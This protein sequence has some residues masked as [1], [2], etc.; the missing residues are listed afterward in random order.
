MARQS[1]IEYP[2]AF[3]HVIVRGNQQQDIFL[4]EDDRAQYLKRLAL[5]KKKHRFYLYAYTLMTNHIHLLLETGDVP[6]SK[7]MQVLNFTYTQYFNRKYNKKGHLFQGRYKSFLCDRDSYLLALVRY[8]HLNP[9]RAGMVK[10]PE[11]YEWSSHRQYLMGTEG[12]I[13]SQEVLMQFSQ[14]RSMSIELYEKFVAEGL[15]QGKED[16]FYEAVDQQILGDDDFVENVTKKVNLQDSPLKKL[17]FKDITRT[18]S[19][20]TGVSLEEMISSKRADETRVSRSLLL[21]VC[22]ERGYTLKELVGPLKRDLSV[23]SRWGKW[24]KEDVMIDLVEKAQT[25][26]DANLQA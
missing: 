17:P 21:R 16:S 1:R 10:K 3:Y 22:C 26:L 19:T 2:G 7:I 14:K 6:I 18:I 25:S 5:Y 23:L 4:D 12:I 24:G 20:I 8:I 9:V 15:S 11:D 13:D